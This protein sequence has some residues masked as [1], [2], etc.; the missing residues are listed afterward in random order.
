MIKA[1][2]E[3]TSEIILD[4]SSLEELKISIERKEISTNKENVDEK[5][6]EKNDE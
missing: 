1:T 3:D 6:K 4:D 2:L 5:E